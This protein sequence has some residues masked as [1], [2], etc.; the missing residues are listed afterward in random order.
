M[1]AAFTAFTAL[2]H[3]LPWSDMCG[4]TLSFQLDSHLVAWE[5]QQ[6]HWRLN[7]CSQ[8][9]HACHRLCARTD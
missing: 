5:S 1:S 7:P 3:E 6:S 9:R 2:L 8:C 4:C